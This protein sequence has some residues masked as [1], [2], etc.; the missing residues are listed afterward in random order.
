MILGYVP[1]L[2]AAAVLIGLGIWGLVFNKNI[3]KM[4]LS[5]EVSFNGVTLLILYLATTSGLIS[6][7]KL[8]AYLVFLGIGLAIG[9][10][11]IIVSVILY[12][13][14]ERMLEELSQDEIRGEE[15]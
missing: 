5:L 2:I 15:S 12:M 6:V 4:L 7:V 11:A 14:K 8:G 9:E 13:F 3:V 10:I 1:I